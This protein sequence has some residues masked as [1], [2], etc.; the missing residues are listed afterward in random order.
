MSF[1]PQ[2]DVLLYS[3]ELS[4]WLVKQ[5]NDTGD[6]VAEILRKVRSHQ[7][8]VLRVSLFFVVVV[9]L[10]LFFDPRDLPTDSDACLELVLSSCSC[11]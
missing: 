8:Y 6:T 1:V 4:L 9:R 2:D 7:A 3:K 11:S 10:S 5:L